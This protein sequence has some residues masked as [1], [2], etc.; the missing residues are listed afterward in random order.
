MRDV[1]LIGAG[2]IGRMVAH[3]LGFSGDY[4][5]RVVDGDQAAVDRICTRVPGA[6]GHAADFTD[7]AALDEVMRGAAAV[8]SCAPFHCNPVIAERAR[9]NRLHYFDLTEDVRVTD[10][11]EA[12]AK[13]AET[14]FVPQ[15][16]LAPG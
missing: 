4:A 12:L 11:V 15:C 5:L 2:K 10:Q 8:V 14:A 13:G 7:P 1:V 9:A 16:G 3:F 6:R